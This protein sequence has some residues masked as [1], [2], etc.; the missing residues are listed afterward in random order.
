MNV[1]DVTVTT[2]PVGSK[3]SFIVE[4]NGSKIRID[5][6]HPVFDNTLGLGE[7]AWRGTGIGLEGPPKGK[8]VPPCFTVVLTPAE[9]PKALRDVFL[10]R[11]HEWVREF[12]REHGRFDGA[13]ARSM[14]SDDEADLTKVGSD[15]FSAARIESDILFDGTPLPSAARIAAEVLKMAGKRA[16]EADEAR[17]KK[18]GLRRD[19]DSE[20]RFYGEI[21]LGF[22]TCKSEL[23]NSPTSEI[24]RSIESDVRDD[25][26]IMIT[27]GV[28]ANM[29]G[30][31]VTHVPTGLFVEVT[32]HR[33]K[34]KNSVDALKLLTDKVVE[35]WRQESERN[36]AQRW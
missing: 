22:D 13:E 36:L 35:F 16:V 27:H 10:K 31:R 18:M 6:A 9:S 3:V 34:I 24:T 5:D 15:I 25:V 8:P 30:V 28:N 14:L 23:F 7:M 12:T 33:S 19:L 2:T 4:S 29:T 11:L 17:L 1:L 26:G 21:F 20:S 32:K